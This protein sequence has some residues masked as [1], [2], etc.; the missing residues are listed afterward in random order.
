MPSPGA[1]RHV[2]R[3]R[4]W[5]AGPVTAAAVEPPLLVLQPPS[6]QNGADCEAGAYRS[7]QKQIA[8]LQA[9]LLNRII[10]RERDRTARCVAEALDIDDDL[11]LRNAQLFRCR[12]DD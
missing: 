3:R 12:Q 2:A 4:A 10:E 11:F 8:F 7:H 5:P 9:L 6:H 1:R